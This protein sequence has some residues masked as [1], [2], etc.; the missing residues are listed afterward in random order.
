VKETITPTL[1]LTPFKPMLVAVPTSPTKWPDVTIHDRSVTPVMSAATVVSAST[2]KLVG[3]EGSAASG[4]N[5]HSSASISH[6][7]LEANLQL[8]FFL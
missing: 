1:M 4:T 3:S 2:E 5:L 7:K 8:V 6:F